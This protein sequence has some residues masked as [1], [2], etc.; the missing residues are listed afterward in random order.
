MTLRARHVAVLILFL[1]AL[2]YLPRLGSTTFFEEDEPR[3]A[4]A[5][6]TMLETGDYVTPRFNGQL[7]INKP[8]LFY[9][10][11]AASSAA[12]GVGELGARLP[13]ALLGTALALLVFL[14][15][16]AHGS[17]R[18]AAIAA[19]A[20]ATCLQF[21]LVLARAATADMALIFFLTGALL[22]F[23]HGTTRPGEKRWFLLS[24]AA[25]GL[26]ALAK[27]PVAVALAGGVV[28]LFLL[29]RGEALPGLR[30]LVTPVGLLLFL[31]VAAPWYAAELALWGKTF[32]RGFFLA[33]H[34]GRLDGTA[35]SHRGPIWFFLPVML[36][37]FYPWVCFLP[38][39]LSG[40]WRER[41]GAAPL[42]LFALCWIVVVLGLFTVVK[43]KLP[44]YIA[45]LYPAAAL[46]AAS[47][48][49]TRLSGVET[50]TWRVSERVLAW[51]GGVFVLAPVA[52]AFLG[53]WLLMDTTGGLLV[54]VGPGPAALAA[55]FA[56]G[57]AGALLLLARRRPGSALGVLITTLVGAALVAH[58]MVAPV[59]A[60][61]WQDPLRHLAEDAAARAGDRGRLALFACASSGVIYY[62]RSVVP[63]L[64]AEDTGR[65]RA[66]AARS[67]LYVITRVKRAPLL[68][69]S[70][71][72]REVRRESG[73]VLL[74]SEQEAGGGR[75]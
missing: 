7:R 72:L 53:P 4:A 75:Q 29:L 54:T 20:T 45:P 18:F 8:I 56:L 10:L 26:A 6:R 25:L 17:V 34:F 70:L 14:F 36:G 74:G 2:L 42:R 55:C 1:C 21:S 73:F 57:W 40:A 5:V 59:I 13:S 67:P 35:D 11:S 27:G 48:W 30:R 66:L 63:R 3:F 58:L 12:L 37:M 69:R 23:Y 22:A 64:R 19:V 43:T 65:L 33:E 41:R 49:E 38:A 9:W 39:G 62:S 71:G 46:L 60:R 50:R 16:R 44:H 51:W 32:Y 68:P 15:A 52:G 47:A 61:H 31:L 28:G 24:W